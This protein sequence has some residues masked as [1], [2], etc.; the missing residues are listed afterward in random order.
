MVTP[1]EFVDR[2]ASSLDM[3]YAT[4]EEER[5]ETTFGVDLRSGEDLYPISGPPALATAENCKRVGF[6]DR[7]ASAGWQTR[8]TTPCFR[9]R[10]GGPSGLEGLGSR[11]LARLP[12]GTRTGTR[13]CLT[14]SAGPTGQ[15][16][17]RHNQA[18]W[19]PPRDVEMAHLARGHVF[20]VQIGCVNKRS[21]LSRNDS[22][23]KERAASDTRR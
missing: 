2:L 8:G 7:E 18:L 3:A 1:A 22:A 12:S 6:D 23:V 21:R 5:A 14:K 10:Y 17:N 16:A 11:H 19:T 9:R 13:C 4:A 15:P 20:G